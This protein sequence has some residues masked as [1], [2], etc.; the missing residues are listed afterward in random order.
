MELIYHL[1]HILSDSAKDVLPLIGVILFFQ[2]VVIKKKID[3]AGNLVY[4]FFLVI[5]GLA[6]F[7][8]GLEEGLFPLGESITSQ[9]TDFH[10]LARGNSAIIK[11]IEQ[12]GLIHSELY[13]WTY[14][15]AFLIGFSTTIAEPALI[16]VA[17]KAEQ[18][19]TGAISSLGL[20]IAVAV[21][22]AIGIT[23]G[24]H[25]IIIGSPLHWYII[26]G[27]IAV[28]CQTYFAPRMIVPLAYDSGGVTTS[29]VTVPL[30]TA[31]GIGLAS[32]VPGRSVLIDAFGLI[33]FASLFP[34][35]VVLAYATIGESIEKIRR[36][37]KSSH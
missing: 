19:T 28:I 17:L 35:I 31:L 37:K 29:T 34:V 6:V 5:I 24:C 22:V 16:A 21:C 1:I 18:I 13:F 3:Q 25:R 15:F 32:N 36:R 27:Y 9:L 7:F 2:L 12:G 11:E 30:V 4:G 14:V 33:A 20:R 10:F 23:I 8:A 26:I